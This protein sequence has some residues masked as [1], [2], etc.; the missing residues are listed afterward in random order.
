MHDPFLL[1][2]PRVKVGKKKG[3]L[4]NQNLLSDHKVRFKGRQVD[5]LGNITFDTGCSLS[6]KTLPVGCDVEILQTTNICPPGLPV[7]TV[8]FNSKKFLSAQHTE[9]RQLCL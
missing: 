1:H 9:V 4:Q 6:K 8:T 5:S 2:F 3:I 7:L